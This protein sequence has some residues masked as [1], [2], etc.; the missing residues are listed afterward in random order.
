MH[1]RSTNMGSMP[2]FDFYS[3]LYLIGGLCS[4]FYCFY[5][6]CRFSKK[7]ADSRRT[8][9]RVRSPWKSPSRMFNLS[10]GETSRPQQVPRDLQAERLHV[11]LAGRLRRKADP[12]LPGDHG[13]QYVQ[14]IS[15]VV[16]LAVYI[17]CM[18]I[19]CKIFRV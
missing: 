13:A 3:L 8:V 16:N 4:R 1:F 9:A 10:A 19:Q 14:L 2:N 15:Q 5:K 11:Q 17:V 7:S 12:R 6:P 18:R